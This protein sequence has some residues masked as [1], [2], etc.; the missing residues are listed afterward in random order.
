LTVFKT[1]AINSK[2]K[3]S[4]E[5][6]RKTAVIASKGIEYAIETV[7]IPEFLS[8]SGNH[9]SNTGFLKKTYKNV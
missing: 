3:V 6:Y 4:P 5:S 8:I 7:I 9:W 2:G 1:G